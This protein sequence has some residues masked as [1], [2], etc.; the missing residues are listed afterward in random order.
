VICP[1]CGDTDS[2]FF[3]RDQRREYLRC[4]ECA[5]VFVPPEFHLDAA[6]ER[7]EYELHHNDPQD[8]GYRRFL[9]RLAQPLS[10]QLA[11]GSRGLDFGCG[12]GP[13]LSLMLA[14]QGHSM[15]LYDPYFAPDSRVFETHWDFITATEVA[16]H[17]YRPGLELARLWSCLVPG[18]VLGLMT[19]L[20]LDRE[21]FSR[22]HYKN[23]PT[24]VCFFM[25][26]SFV[27]L[28]AQWQAEVSFPAQDVILLGKK[29]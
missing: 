6:A 23:D 25:R 20:V 18:G 1:L 12:P 16:E 14:E 13:T 26:A 11:P 8:A 24:H 29:T 2:A 15:R 7:T 4:G 19:K 27:W 3:H 17:L 22:W 10:A 28:G 5:L 21:A 9:G